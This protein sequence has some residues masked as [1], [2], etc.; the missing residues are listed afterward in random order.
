MRKVTLITLFGLLQCA[1]FIEQSHAEDLDEKVAQDLKLVQSSVSDADNILGNIDEGMSKIRDIINSIPGTD[2]KKS[3]AR[4]KYTHIVDVFGSQKKVIEKM[5]NITSKA[6]LTYDSIQLLR[7]LSGDV[8]N[9]GQ[10]GDLGAQFNA[11]TTLL[12][13]LGDVPVLGAAIETYGK[14]AAEMVNAIYRVGDN[15]DKV[16]NQGQIGGQGYYAAGESAVLYNKLVKQFGKSFAENA[17]LTPDQPRYVYR[18]DSDSNSYIWNE[19]QKKWYKTDNGAPLDEI[20]NK[21][22]QATQKLLDAGQLNVLANNWPRIQKREQSANALLQQLK[23]LKSRVGGGKAETAFGEV[24]GK[25]ELSHWADMGDDFAISYAYDSAFKSQV[26]RAVRD[27]YRKLREAGAQS[28]SQSLENWAND[29]NVSLPKVKLTTEADLA[30]IAEKQAEK[31]AK[32]KEKAERLER[33]QAEREAKRLAKE[34]AR[35]ER[36]AARQAEKEAREKEKAE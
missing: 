35:A 5:K 9:Y 15:I 20:Y 8:K 11:L 7:T 10:G 28:S 29:A 13:G 26:D 23:D 24:D 31:E 27:L 25:Y 18:S 36:E 30:R 34:E 3:E 16:R 33:Q 17:R 1:V 22:R 19:N 2:P 6:N 14:V 4:D 21:H 12:S 32:E